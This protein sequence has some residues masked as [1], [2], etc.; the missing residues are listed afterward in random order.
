M[1]VVLYTRNNLQGFYSTLE[2]L[3]FSRKN[4]APAMMTDWIK[5]HFEKQ[6]HD[7]EAIMEKLVPQYKKQHEIIYDLL[8]DNTEKEIR[9]L[10]LGCGNGVLSKLV[11]GKLPKAHVVGFDLTPQMLESY[12]KNL[13]CYEGRF[14][15]IEG[16]FRSD[17]I[18]SSYDLVLA[19]LTL[20]HLTWGQRKEFYAL[21]YDILNPGGSFILNDIIIDQDWDKRNRQYDNWMKFIE[22]NGEDPNYWFDKHMDKD[23][24]VTLEDHFRWLKDAGFSQVECHWRHY[25][26]AITSATKEA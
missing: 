19:G 1:Q 17:S 15:L 22:A 10:D 26:F 5:E 25:N 16:D 13:S 8:P 6:A 9:V 18:G 11:L 21:I 2:G 23:Y 14:E 20:Q 4:E 7:Y 12:V 24:P 3:I